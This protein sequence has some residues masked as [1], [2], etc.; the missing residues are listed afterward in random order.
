MVER[1]NCHHVHSP[2][3]GPIMEILSPKQVSAGMNDEEIDSISEI[4]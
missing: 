1:Q 3:Q 2:M 4:I